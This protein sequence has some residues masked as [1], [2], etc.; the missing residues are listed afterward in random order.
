MTDQW[1]TIPAFNG[2]VAQEGNAPWFLDNTPALKAFHAALNKYEPGK[3]V[4]D[5]SIEGWASGKLFQA[6]VAASGSKTVTTAS[7]LAG[8]YSL[9][10]DTLGGIAPPITYTKGSAATIPCFF[11]VGISKGKFVAP[12]GL[13]TS[14]A[15]AS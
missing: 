7:V 14:C 10:G 12:Q 1:L 15:P 8:L 13:K 3:A 6:A 2:T 9:K 4:N 5:S 11:I